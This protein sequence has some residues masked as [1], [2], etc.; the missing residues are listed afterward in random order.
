MIRFLLFF[1]LFISPNI[2][3]QQMDDRWYLGVNAGIVVPDD[4]LQL[5]D[6]Q[7]VDVRM[8]KSFNKVWSYEIQA[9]SDEYNFDI[10]YGL[11]HHGLMLNF[12]NI[13]QEPLW[14]PYFIV[15]GG[16]IYHRSPTESGINPVFNVG[17]GA[18]W[19]FFGDNIRL[20]AEAVSRMDLN[21]TNLPGQDGF[22]D[23][24]FTMGLTIPLGQ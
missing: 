17:I 12:L 7:V 15:G 2:H 5:T 3:A 1:S 19:Y 10:N 14:K 20:R 21:S 11:I 13:N 4:S 22:G 6:A 16:F 24:V 8:G 18:S 23:G 9:F